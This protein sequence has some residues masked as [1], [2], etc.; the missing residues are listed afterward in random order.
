MLISRDRP[1]D[2]I[3]EITRFS[4]RSVFGINL[5]VVNSY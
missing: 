5:G 2:E 1:K 4:R 3:F